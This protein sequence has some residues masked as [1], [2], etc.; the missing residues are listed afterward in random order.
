MATVTGYQRIS[1]DL[2]CEFHVY[3]TDHYLRG[4]ELPRP[5]PRRDP[6]CNVEGLECSRMDND[7][8]RVPPYWTREYTP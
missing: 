8:W 2:V 5:G 4:Y 3:W 1:I 6:A 7:H